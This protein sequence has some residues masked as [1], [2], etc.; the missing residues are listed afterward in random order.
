MNFKTA[1]DNHK[2]YARI[3]KEEDMTIEEVEEL[4]I[5][6]LNKELRFP[7]LNIG[8]DEVEKFFSIQYCLHCVVNDKT[9]LSRLINKIS[10]RKM[11][12]K[13]SGKGTKEKPY[14]L[15]SENLKGKCFNV[16][17]IF[18]DKKCPFEVGQCFMNSFNISGEMC[19]LENIEHCD[20]V[21]GISL[22]KRKGET[23]SILHSVVELNNKWV[24]DVNLGMVVSKNLYFKLF[25]FEELARYEGKRAEEILE[26]LDREATRE[27]SRQFNLKCYHMNFAVDD[28]I[29]FINNQSRRN[30]HA[31]FRELNY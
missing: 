2:I 11:G 23:K 12:L 28:F 27:I 25:M 21:S 6:E 26:I 5:Q 3:F 9:F 7:N 1:L 20:C 22:T 4:R 18:S 29:D 15:E 8:T 17:H 14:I 16:K 31:A 10:L 30:V 24:V 13:I 19:K